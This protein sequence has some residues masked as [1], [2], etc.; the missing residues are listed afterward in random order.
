MIKNIISL[1]VLIG[2]VAAA[3]YV[4]SYKKSSGPYFEAVKQEQAGNYP[5]AISLYIS[6]LTGMTDVHP[7]PSKSQGMASP[8]ETWIKE[9][10][11]Y[12]DWLLMTPTPSK[13]LPAVAD[14]I[15]RV[16]KHIENQNYFIELSIKKATIEEYGKT[17][18]GIF[19]P[20]GKAPPSGQ[21]S[22]LEKAMDTSISI[23]TMIGN[24]SYQY[25]GKAINRATGKCQDFTVFNDGQF[26]LLMPPGN[27][28]LIVTSKATFP[29]GQMWM[30][31]ANALTLTVP[32]LTSLLSMKLK[33]DIKRRS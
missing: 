23:L 3:V 28:Y 6:A 9:L 13:R 17:W 15:E 11:T 16:G 8:P 20:E 32:D 31:P 4:F 18:N 7:L 19:Y 33:T 5:L 30:S 25:N 22:L 1:L 21:Q 29:S 26:S 27:Y 24:P 14:A 2:I 12:T 10:N